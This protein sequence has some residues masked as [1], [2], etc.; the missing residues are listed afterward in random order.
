MSDA[1]DWRGPGEAP[2]DYFPDLQAMGDCAVC[3]HVREDHPDAMP[4]RPATSLLDL[5]QE[6]EYA[7]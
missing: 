2:H 3:G 5:M 1:A 4:K 6:V 7:S